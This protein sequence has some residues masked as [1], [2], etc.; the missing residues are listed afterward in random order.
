MRLIFFAS[1]LLIVLAG[2][3]LFS[4]NVVVINSVDVETEK[5]DCTDVYKIRE[6]SGVLGQNLLLLDFK[7]I[8]SDLK[9]NFLC[10]RKVE[11]LR[12]FPDKVRLL[13]IG[14]EPAAIL[15]L[16]KDQEATESGVLEKFSEVWATSSA[17][18]S[19]SAGFN[20]FVEGP[21]ENFVVDNEGV[22]YSTDIEQINAPKVFVSGL[23]LNL[24]Q[25]IKENLITNLLKILEKVR[26]FGIEARE[27][28]IYS[29]HLLLV[30]SMPRIIFRL[31]G[32]IDTQI[33]SLQLILQ[34]AKIDEDIL[35]FIDLRFDKQIVRF[36][37]KKNGQ[38]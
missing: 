17:E 26:S 20:F 11:G 22:V 15:V 25:K 30:N 33:A 19:P 8:E 29:N 32:K 6:S 1:I 16:S 2:S 38:R 12:I 37:P 28:K 27:T 9:N 35:E 14:R 5:V 3:M 18:A 21:V 23:N 34:K 31:D 10:I 4:S 13:V 7:K 24:G 36:A